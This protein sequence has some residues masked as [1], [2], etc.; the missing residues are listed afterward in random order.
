MEEE[1]KDFP[2]KGSSYTNR[3]RTRQATY[4]NNQASNISYISIIQS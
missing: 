2:E 3:Q 1:K 4:V